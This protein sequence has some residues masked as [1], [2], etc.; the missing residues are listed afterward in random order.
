MGDVQSRQDSVKA[1]LEF[2]QIYGT[3]EQY[4]S[5]TLLQGC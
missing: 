4:A 2:N 1:G 3:N 5:L